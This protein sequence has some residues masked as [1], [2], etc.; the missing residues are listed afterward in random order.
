MLEKRLFLVFFSILLGAADLSARAQVVPSATLKGISVTAGGM[1][2]I[3][4]PDF[5]GTAV[6]TQSS[7]TYLCYGLTGVYC[8]PA[9]QASPYLLIGLG[10]YVDVKYNRWIQ[11][12]AEGRW[13]RFNQFQNISQDNYL[14][15][16]RIPVYRFWK[17]QFYG[18]ALVGEG[19]MTFPPSSSLMAD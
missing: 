10:A 3:F 18:K 7:T 17:A 16:P 9:A 2:S 1:G 13:M 12:E 5:E 15:G 19:K 14:I 4:Q 11:I 6:T 8:I